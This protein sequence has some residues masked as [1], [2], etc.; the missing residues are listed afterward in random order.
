MEMKNE[1]TSMMFNP[2]EITEEVCKIGEAK[3]SKPFWKVLLSAFLAGFFIGLGYYGYLVL[4]GNSVMTTVPFFGKFL[5]AILFPVG[6]VMIV[7]AGGDL[8]TGNCLLTMGWLNK[9][10][11]FSKVL[12]NL[13]LVYLGNLLGA[14]ALAGL[15]SLSQTASETTREYILEVA[16]GKTD[17]SFLEAMARGIL[18]N[19]LVSLAVYMSYAAKSVGSKVIVLML[20]ILLFVI[21]GYEHSVANMFVLP[22]AKILGGDFT[23]GEMLLSNLLPVTIG[24]IIG[25]GVIV[26][27]VYYLIFMR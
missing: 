11:S 21:S 14:L 13:G 5:G 23:I 1:P 2:K 19:I 7:I 24:N 20:P 26:P 8:F 12:A 3:V 4:A 17:L 25:G 15:M 18:C 27:G 10:Y 6:L 16:T 9:R 22:F